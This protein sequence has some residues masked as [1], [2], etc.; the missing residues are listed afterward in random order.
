MSKH[1][2]IGDLDPASCRVPGGSIDGGTIK[3]LPYIEDA[4]AAA[5]V[6]AESACWCCWC[7]AADAV[8]GGGTMPWLS[9]PGGSTSG[10]SGKAAMPCIIRLHTHYPK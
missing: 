4:T 1:P 7:S 10:N 8:G 6:A 5:A 3:G 9:R 2:A